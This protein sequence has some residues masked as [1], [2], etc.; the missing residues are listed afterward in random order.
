MFISDLHLG[1]TGYLAKKVYVQETA[2]LSMGTVHLLGKSNGGDPGVDHDLM[3]K[4]E[5]QI[6]TA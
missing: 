1:T 5:L 3:T 2:N 4:G 6:S